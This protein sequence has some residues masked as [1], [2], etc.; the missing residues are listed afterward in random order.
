MDKEMKAKIDEILKTNG[1]RELSMEE[2]EQVAGGNIDGL[3]GS[4]GKYYD[5]VTI[6]NLARGMSTTFGFDIA[7]PA[8][9]KLFCLRE[10]EIAKAHMGTGEDL[11]SMDNLLNR[12][13]L[14]H[15][16]AREDGKTF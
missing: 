3:V 10:T 9:C 8:I 14:T 6:V 15:E 1:R 13:F 7:A 2:A 12:L 16:H 5:Y 11:A 4:D